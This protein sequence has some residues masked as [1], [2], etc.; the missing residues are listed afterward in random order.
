MVVTTAHKLAEKHN[1]SIV[2]VSHPVKGY[3][4]PSL[5]SLA[6]GA[7]FTRHVDLVLW[8]EAIDPKTVTVAGP[9]GRHET[10]IDRIMHLLKV[11]HG[12]GHGKRIGFCFD[13]QSLSLAEQ[14]LILKDKKG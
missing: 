8:L 3:E 11:R 9:C 5:D 4:R 10:E 14:G 2:F 12:P 7:A 6:G 1:T 13:V